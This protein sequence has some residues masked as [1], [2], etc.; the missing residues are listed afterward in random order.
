ML[1]LEANFSTR[2][3]TTLILK[4]AKKAIFRWRP[5]Q[6]FWLAAKTKKKPQPSAATR[7]LL[8]SRNRAFCDFVTEIAT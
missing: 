2:I 1:Q 5:P 8:G 6:A 3:P 4:I 7:A